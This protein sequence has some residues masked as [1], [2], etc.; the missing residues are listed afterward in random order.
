MSSRFGR[1]RSTK[2]A[3]GPNF[4]D[5]GG[6]SGLEIDELWPNPAPTQPPLTFVGAAAND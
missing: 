4:V 6:P 1:L 2:L 3:S 5:L